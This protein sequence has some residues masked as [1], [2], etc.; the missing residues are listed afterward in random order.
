MPKGYGSAFEILP[1]LKKDGALRVALRHAEGIARSA[2]P[3]NAGARGNAVPPRLKCIILPLNAEK[4]YPREGGLELPRGGISAAGLVSRRQPGIIG[5]LR[6]SE[7]L[8]PLH[9]GEG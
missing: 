6:T 3:H 1:S 7:S 4:Y 5:S 2:L 9:R 8:G